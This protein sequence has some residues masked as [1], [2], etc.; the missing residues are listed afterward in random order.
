ML[1]QAGFAE[2]NRGLNSDILRF[3]HLDHSNFDYEAEM[4]AATKK[5]ETAHDAHP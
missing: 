3:A 1:N 2:E 4:K 5:F